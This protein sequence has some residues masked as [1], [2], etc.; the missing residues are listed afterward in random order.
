LTSLPQS[1]YH[2]AERQTSQR[3]F[4]RG[5]IV[6]GVG[7]HKS[8]VGSKSIV[9]S[10]PQSLAAMCPAPVTLVDRGLQAVLWRM[11]SPSAY[12]T[13]FQSIGEPIVPGRSSLTSERFKLALVHLDLAS[14]FGALCSE[15]RILSISFSKTCVDPVVLLPS[16]FGIL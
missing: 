5:Q 13:R 12:N 4:R 3:D 1:R 6:E 11:C 8:F 7:D 15:I 16:Y 2:T 9:S 10:P 14:S